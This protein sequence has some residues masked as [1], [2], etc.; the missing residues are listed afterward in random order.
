MRPTVLMFGLP[1]S[2]DF[3][4][5][6]SFFRE[7]ISKQ[8]NGGNATV[9]LI[10]DLAVSG[11]L[12]PSRLEI[13]CAIYHWAVGETQRDAARDALE[14]IVKVYCRECNTKCEVTFQCFVD[15][16]RGL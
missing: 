4:Q 1:D 10:P 5:K 13:T 11:T 12:M 16:P 8:V 9:H 14:A 6:I 7:R 15:D 3:L 2:P